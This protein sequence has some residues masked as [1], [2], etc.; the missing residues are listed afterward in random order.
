MSNGSPAETKPS[1]KMTI[2]LWIVTIAGAIFWL[3]F[4]V[5][6]LGWII[7]AG[8]P[9]V[10]WGVCILFTLVLL[11]LAGREV[12]GRWLGILIDARNKYSLARLQIMIWT[13]M[14]MTAY[15][16]IALPRIRLMAQGT[17]TQ[18][19][20]L[21]TFQNSSSQWASAV[22]FAGSSLIKRTKMSKTTKIDCDHS[23]AN[24]RKDQ[25]ASDLKDAEL[26]CAGFG[27]RPPGRRLDAAKAA[28]L[29]R[30]K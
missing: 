24:T 11:V 28:P 29:P 22:S 30:T 12:N 13:V 6:F 14:V 7:P 15:L 2:A 23:V 18:A 1:G 17:L 21:N 8:G 26:A 3:R 20:A 9:A 5:G 4:A 19:D 27:S 16:T 10:A 25:A